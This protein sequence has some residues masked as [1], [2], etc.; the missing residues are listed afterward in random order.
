MVERAKGLLGSLVFVLVL[1]DAKTIKR[2]LGHFQTL[3]ESIATY[4]DQRLTEYALLAPK[5]QQLL[6]E[7]NATNV[8]YPRDLCLHELFEM[9]T[10]RT[11]EAVALISG[12]ERLTYRELNERAN[13]VAH[14]L[15]TL[16]V[17]S[18]SL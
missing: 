15:H 1:F 16:G 11:P 9:Q 13:Y 5:E 7:W 18:E 12:D 14:H 2:M 17:G 10:A 6:A 4:P 3:L 8:D